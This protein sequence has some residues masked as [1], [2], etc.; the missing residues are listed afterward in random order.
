DGFRVSADTRHHRWHATGHCFQQGVA[1]PFTARKQAESI[2]HL[3][4][5]NGVR[6]K[7]Q[8]LDVL[9]KAHRANHRLYFQRVVILIEAAGN[10]EDGAWQ[11][12]ADAL[13]CADKH[14][15]AFDPSYVGHARDDV[16]SARPFGGGEWILMRFTGGNVLKINSVV[17]D[18]DFLRSDPV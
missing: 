8:E 10:Q 14:V 5:G 6:D 1:E 15:N 3:E 16:G 12:T 9:F 13:C 18:R 4:Q 11:L 7:A 17:N 2:A